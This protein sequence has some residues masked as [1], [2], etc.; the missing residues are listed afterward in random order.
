MRFCGFFAPHQNSANQSRCG[1]VLGSERLTG[2][3]GKK[4]AVS[5]SRF[6]GA[7]SFVVRD[8]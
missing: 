6:G 7:S 1:G 4:R 2:A 3:L 8:P 5:V